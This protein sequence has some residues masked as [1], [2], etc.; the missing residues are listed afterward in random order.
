MIW[1]Q[2][3]L[4]LIYLDLV[5]LGDTNVSWEALMQIERHYQ[6][7]GLIGWETQCRL[8]GTIVGLRN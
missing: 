1:W 7:C 5:V 8:A 6:Q 2:S 3:R 4:I